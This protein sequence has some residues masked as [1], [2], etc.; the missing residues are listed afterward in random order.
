[1]A[2]AVENHPDKDRIINAL[3]SGMSLRKLAAT[4][5]P[6]IHF[7]S[8]QRYKLQKVRP[9]TRNAHAIA[10]ILGKSK[11]MTAE[12]LADVT[13]ELATEAIL[14]APVADP[15]LA[16]TAQHRQTIDEALIDAK[17]DKDGKTI[18]VLIGTDLKGLE[19]DARLTGRLESRQSGPDLALQFM[20]MIPRATVAAE[21]SP[22]IEV[23][24]IESSSK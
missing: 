15:Y 24:A 8:L 2:L 3:L 6:P 13:R 20:V 21:L 23:K 18:A 11:A 10:K 16:R 17:A 19:L 1:M 5:D 9:V 14:A 7:T 22:T 4:L 12:Q